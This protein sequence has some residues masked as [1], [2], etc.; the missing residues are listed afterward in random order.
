MKFAGTKRNTYSKQKVRELRDK[1]KF[2]KPKVEGVYVSK[3]E[4]CNRCKLTVAAGVSTAYVKLSRE[5]GTLT[6]RECDNMM[7]DILKYQKN[8]IS[9]GDI[10]AKAI[11]GKYYQSIPGGTFRSAEAPSTAPDIFGFNKRSNDI[12]KLDVKL[13]DALG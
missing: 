7:V 8:Q 6:Q 1:R 4:E 2:A 5:V 12:T 9:L 13:K 11:A 10:K 3:C